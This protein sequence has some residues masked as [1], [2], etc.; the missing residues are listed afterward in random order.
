M[1]ALKKHFY[2]ILFIFLICF[3]NVNSQTKEFPY[4]LKK[5]N[6]IILLT[7]AFS[8]SLIF[9][10]IDNNFPIDYLSDNE[11]IKLT[12][13]DINSFDRSAT[14]NWSEKS[15][16][17][18]DYLKLGMQ[19]APVLLAFPE[20]K[21]KNWNTILT[22]GVMYFE[23]YLLNSS[24]TG[25]TKL[26]VQRKRPFLYNT[27]LDDAKRIDLGASESSYK[28]FYSGHSS[29]TFFNAVFISQVITDV[30]GKSTF[31]YIVWGLSLSAAAATGYLRYDAGQH[32]PTDI[33][34]GAI[35][36]SAIGYLIPLLHKTKTDRIMIFVTNE[37]GIGMVINF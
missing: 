17:A 16:K 5:T 29:S 15:D 27:S 23:G 2:F 8:T 35:T 30:Y 1:Q 4:K 11:I 6:D 34:V 7:T 33:I 26:V 10:Y 21:N 13:E 18:S 12:R 24:L 32:F 19:Y 28:S 25:S 22:L 3:S 20:I 14:Y 31:S 9:Y 36:G 37:K